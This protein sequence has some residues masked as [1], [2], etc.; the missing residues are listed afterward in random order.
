MCKRNNVKNS[1]I[2][3]IKF[4]PSRT[5]HF[6]RMRG[7]SYSIVCTW[8]QGSCF[9]RWKPYTILRV[10]EQAGLWGVLFALQA[11]LSLTLLPI[12]GVCWR[13]INL[14]LPPEGGL[15]QLLNFWWHHSDLP[16]T[17]RQIEVKWRGKCLIFRTGG[18]EPWP[19]VATSD[20]HPDSDVHMPQ[21]RLPTTLSLLFSCFPSLL[22]RDFCWSL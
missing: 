10:G 17:N 2:G 7:A 15:C 11:V 5:L 12:Q 21:Q 14:S 22:I 19:W 16:S 20:S 4:K 8:L 1:Q 6:L 13:Y 18:Y 9:P 3:Q